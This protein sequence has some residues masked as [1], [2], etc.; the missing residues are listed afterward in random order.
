[1]DIVKQVVDQ[2]TGKV[3]EENASFFV[4]FAHDAEKQKSFAFLL[5][6]VAAYLDIDIAEAAQYL[7]DGGN[8]GGFDAAYITQSGEGMLNVV[9]FQA[10]YTRDLEKESN[11]PA[12]AVEKSVNTI[13]NIFDSGRQM[14]LNDKSR[15]TVDEIRSFLADGVIP[16]VTFVLINNGLKWNQDAQN[17]IDNE[18]SDQR[19]V[20]FVYFNHHDIIKYVNKRDKIDEI[21]NLTGAAI[22]ED[23]NYKEVI[24]GRVSVKEIARLLEKYGDS[25]LDKNIRKYLGINAVNKAIHDTLLDNSKRPNFFFYNNGITMICSD[26]KYNALQKE[27][28]KVQTQ[29]LQIIN[30]G[31]TC[32][33]IYQAL[34]DNSDIDFSDTT[35][36]LRLYAVGTDESVIDGITR[37]TN[38]QNPVDFRDLKSND[39]IQ[40]LL[41][42][43]AKEL[44]YVYK[45]KKDN[46]TNTEAIPSSVA[47]ESVFAVWRK[48]PHLAK[49][50]KGEFFDAYYDDIFTNLNAAQMIIA[51]LI[52]RMCD[53]YRKKYSMNKEIEAQRRY[54][55]YLIAAIIGTLILKRCNITIEGIT[56]INFNKIKKYFDDNQDDLYYDAEQLLLSRL[57]RYFGEEDLEK[58]DGR[59]M[60]AVFRRFDFVENVLKIL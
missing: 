17:H 13:K 29:S 56:H 23:F 3:I 55:H 60:A 53:N 9:L 19:Q 36:L 38:S 44:G 24:L 32:K 2:R 52:F 18:F 54:S 37:A 21:L 31:Q 16:Y 42:Q 5:L 59:S 20:E 11:F 50:K 12:N 6:G 40:L 51:V 26:F 14:R 7:T 35:V 1:M 4:D 25:L 15:V 47:A 43:G 10:K 30:G 46:Q 58:L 27:D 48:K 8:D 34:K 41:E 57:K 33:T 22:K 39:Q 49:Y 45:R 28:W